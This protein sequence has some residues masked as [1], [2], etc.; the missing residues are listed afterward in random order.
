MSTASFLNNVTSKAISI[1]N[2]A[3]KFLGEEIFLPVVYAKKDV[4][5]VKLK[6]LQIETSDGIGVGRQLKIKIEGLKELMYSPKLDIT[7]FGALA[8]PNTPVLVSAEV[9]TVNTDTTDE[10]LFFLETRPIP[11]L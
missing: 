8:Y 1:R 2:A 6:S 3:F 11:A 9:K 7:G 5:K 4:A 10:D